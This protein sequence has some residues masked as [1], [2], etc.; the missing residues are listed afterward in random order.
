M[1]IRNLFPT[2][3]SDQ[4]THNLF[5]RLNNEMTRILDDFES[6]NAMDKRPG[7]LSF[8]TT[9][10]DCSETD[11]IVE[12]TVEI[13]GVKEEDIN[14]ELNG[15]LLSISGKREARKDEKQKEYQ[16]IERESGS[17]IRRLDLDFD[18]DPDKVSA[19]VDAG[20]LT[21]TIEK[22]EHTKSKKQKISVKSKN[23]V[24]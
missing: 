13:P 21:V 22:P 9:K 18:A 16:I 12:I 11:N 1:S 19:S 24:G 20:V 3:L 8:L 17:F 15:R 14:V 6:G 7:N 23:A 5:S 10:M 2:L 4:S